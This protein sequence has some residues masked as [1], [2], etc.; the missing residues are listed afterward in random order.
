MHQT[1]VSKKLARYCAELHEADLNYVKLQR[2]EMRQTAPISEELRQT[3]LSCAKLS[4]AA[5]TGWGPVKLS[6]K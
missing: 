1:N 2:T 4:C 3:E 5:I 6:T